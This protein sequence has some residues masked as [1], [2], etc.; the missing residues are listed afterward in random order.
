MLER[1]EA[2]QRSL[3]RVVPVEGAGHWLYVQEQE[4]CLKHVLDFI[5]AENTFAT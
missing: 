5:R 1:E 2:E 4:L 3:C